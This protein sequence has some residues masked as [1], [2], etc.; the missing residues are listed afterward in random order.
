MPVIRRCHAPTCLGHEGDMQTPRTGRVA[1]LVVTKASLVGALTLMLAASCTGTQTEEASPPASA[2]AGSPS[3]EATPS[4]GEPVTDYS[5]FIGNLKAAGFTVREGER[6]EGDQLFRAGQRVFI[7]GA[8]ISTYEFPTEKALVEWRSSVSQDG[9]SI[10]TRGGGVA[11]VEWVA[12][13][14]FYDAGTLLVL[15]FGDRPVILDGL[16]YLL[17][18]QFAGS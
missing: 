17:G 4:P 1:S 3:P 5:S 16:A 13:P 6:T 8:R 2:A 12:P 10:P 9:Y 7:D 14:H 15:Y 18:P 11:M